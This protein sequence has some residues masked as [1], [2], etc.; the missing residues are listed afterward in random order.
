MFNNN[1]LVVNG[2]K[3]DLESNASV[4]VNGSLALTDFL[5]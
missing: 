4:T 1:K 5:Q 2:E 3:T